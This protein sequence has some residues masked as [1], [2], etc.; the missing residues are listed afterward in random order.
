MVWF[1][2][3]WYEYINRVDLGTWK[4][5]YLLP[6]PFSLTE[7][8]LWLIKE[9][10]SCL[11]SYWQPS[12]SCFFYIND[13]MSRLHLILD[14]KSNPNV[15]EPS[16]DTITAFVTSTPHAHK[17]L[18]LERL[19][20]S[21]LVWIKSF[22]LFIY[23]RRDINFF[24][25][26]NKFVSVFLYLFRSIFDRFEWS[27]PTFKL[28]IP[29]FLKYLTMSRFNKTVYKWHYFLLMARKRKICQTTQD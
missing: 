1:A 14:E 22:Y 16:V 26:H 10:G 6:E 11:W 24:P 12:V 17:I 15:K 29:L 13:S 23:I 28:R 3:I 7:T 2:C 25:D 19:Y 9:L 27:C 8:G 20:S 4:N 5:K 21:R 18:F